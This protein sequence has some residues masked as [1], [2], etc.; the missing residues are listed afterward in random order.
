MSIRSVARSTSFSSKISANRSRSCD[1]SHSESEFRFHIGVPRSRC[2]KAVVDWTW[3]LA[4][5]ASKNPMVGSF[6]GCC[7][8]MPSGHIAV[9]PNRVMKHR[10]GPTP[11]PKDN[12]LTAKM[13]SLI[14]LKLG[15]RVLALNTVQCLCWVNRVTLTARRSL[16]VFTYELT[17][18]DRVDWSVPCQKA[19][20]QFELTKR[21]PTEAASRKGMISLCAASFKS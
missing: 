16:P 18:S 6:R 2:T 21:P 3:A 9:P 14:G 10:C 7:A 17:S 13:N 1:L 8:L 19:T 15:S 20:S 11:T 4:E 5:L 12:I